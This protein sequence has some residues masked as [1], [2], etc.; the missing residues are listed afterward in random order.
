MRTTLVALAAV[1][2]LFALPGAAEERWPDDYTRLLL[3]VTAVAVHGAN[4][5]VWTT[6]WTV[7]NDSEARAYFVGPFPYLFLSPPVQIN[8]VEPAAVK[9]LAVEQASPGLDG[10]FVYVLT[11]QLERLS[12]SL[13]V[14]DV[15]VNAQ[16]YGTSIPIVRAEEFRREVQ[17]L[18]VPTDP[19]YR[20]MLRV[21]GSEPQVV[22]IAAYT[23]AG[24]LI[25]QFDAVLNPGNESELG[26]LERPAYVQL[27]PLSDAIRA[28]GDHVRLEISAAETGTPIWAFVS[29]S[30]NQTQQ[31]TAVVP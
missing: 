19:A 20:A 11:S 23:A 21:Y 16:S 12:M 26:E 2:H 15:S 17:L 4:G 10:A 25:E 31:V 7:F 9:R 5:S 30:H 3:P 28:A 8:E 29:I 1:L 6:E 24:Q 18:D 13:R 22:R 27:D 14:R